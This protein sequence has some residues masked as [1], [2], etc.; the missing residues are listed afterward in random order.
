MTAK[1]LLTNQEVIIAFFGREIVLGSVLSLN[2]LK[3]ISDSYDSHGMTS[4][5]AQYKNGKIY[6]ITLFTKPLDENGVRRNSDELIVNGNTHY[7]IYLDP[8]VIIKY[9]KSEYN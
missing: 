4:F 9:A 1:K 7:E 8:V 6:D 3:G 5:S 2:D